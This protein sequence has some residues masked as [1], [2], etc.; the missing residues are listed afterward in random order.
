M[1]GADSARR[2]RDEVR[3]AV[4][5]AWQGGFPLNREGVKAKVRR[6]AAEV[7]GTIENLLSER[8]LHEVAIAP[9][10]RTNPRRGAFLVNLTTDEHEAA[11][12]GV[13]LPAAKLFVP[14]SWRK[15]AAPSIPEPE[16]TTSEV[17]P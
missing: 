4:D 12:R 16:C 1:R 8:W 7:A 13:R 5:S 14:E 17:T 6:R 15:P 11:L 9:K 2:V 10:E 3:A